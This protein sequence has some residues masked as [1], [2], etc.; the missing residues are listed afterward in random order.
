MKPNR[1]LLICALLA[2][3]AVVTS[4]SVG[5][6]SVPLFPWGHWTP[7][8]RFIL[9]DLRL[10]R[11]V[12]AFIVG[13]CL[14]VSG[15]TLQATLQNPLADPYIL[16]VSAGAG[17]GAALALLTPLGNMH[18]LVVPLFAFGG[19]LF[20]VVL[21]Y[22]IVQLSRRF[23][24][25]HIILA[26]IMVN[27]FFSSLTLLAVFLSGNRLVSLMYWLMGDLGKTDRTL[28]LWLTVCALAGTAIAVLLS[29]TA[30]MMTFGDD[31]AAASGVSVERHRKWMLVTASFLVGIA[32]A[33]GGIIGF[34]G[35]VIPHILRLVMGHDFRPLSIASGLLGGA[36][37]VAMDTLARVLL[38]TTELPV[39]LLTSF[40]GAPFFLWLFLKKRSDA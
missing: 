19:A 1:G 16:G 33:G 30:N 7:T 25:T 29:R 40:I 11:T 20:T 18:P 31:T 35:L 12:T 21:V 32:V 17:L 28:L 5:T 10:I 8:E 39:G 23:S 38:P 22:G 6:V 27:A 2:I 4:V 37:L 13:S 36:F 24:V 9:I 14:G 15:I 3:A 26:G 34:V